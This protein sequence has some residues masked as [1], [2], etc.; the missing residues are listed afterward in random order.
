MPA[1][2]IL[3]A[4]G[5]LTALGAGLVML[6]RISIKVRLAWSTVAQM[7]FMLVECGL[8]LYTLAA[9]HLLGHS[10][11]KAH[12]FLAASDVV[13]QTR[14]RAL[15]PPQLPARASLLAA[16][17]LAGAVV[18]AVGGGWPLWWTGVM[19]LAWAP[20]LWA[21][22]LRQLVA[23]LA[24]TALLTAVARAAHAL[25]LGLHDAPHDALGF[26]ALA[27]MAALYAVLV[28]LQMRPQALLTARRWSYAGF[29]LDEFYTR[30]SLRLWLAPLDAHAA[31]TAPRHDLTEK[32]EN[33]AHRHP[34]TRR[35][36][37]G[38]GA[39]PHPGCLRPGLQRDRPPPGRWTAPSPSTRT[40]SA[41]ASRCAASPRAWRCWAASRCFRRASA[42]AR[43]GRAGASP[44]RT[45]PWHCSACR[46][47]PAW[48][49][50]TASPRWTAPADC[51]RCRC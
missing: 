49:R 18:A 17:L 40:G 27:G 31:P 9:L 8:G 47:R 37:P 7:G 19:A 38:R 24:A 4:L 12:A 21:S 33:H 50:P 45:W 28:A 11:Y 30:W 36:G 39:R 32:E 14:A 23:G 20:L 3:V 6:T 22:T 44:R 51:S 34:R 10:I 26:L 25:P 43:P 15:R 2:A 42:S 46:M 35:P 13:R 5:L 1:R 29:Y 41:R 48:P 16:P